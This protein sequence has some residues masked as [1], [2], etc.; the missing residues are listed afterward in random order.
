MTICILLMSA[1]LACGSGCSSTGSS[2]VPES[3]DKEP[4]RVLSKTVPVADP[5]IMVEKGKYYLYGTK[6]GEALGFDVYVSN[7]LEKW[8]MYSSAL[9]PSDSYGTTGFW[10]P[11]V[12]YVSAKKKYYMFY[13]AERRLCVAESSSPL[14]AFVQ[15]FKK[16]MRE[17]AGIDSS[18]F[19]DTDGKAYIYFVRFNGGN[20]IWGAELKDDLK[21][22]KE[23]TL[24]RCIRPDQP[25]ELIASKVTE[26]PSVFKKDGV[27][28]L[29]Y[30][31]NDYT[32]QDYAVGYATSSSPLGPWKK[33]DSN[34]VLHKYE[35]LVGVG[36]GAPFVDND[37][38]MRY[39][40][41][42]HKS[43]TEVHPRGAYI[44][45]MNV[46][47]GKISMGGGLIKPVVVDR[48]AE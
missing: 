39:V 4:V 14:G 16:P 25:W 15:T 6:N 8:K 17:E 9:D 29:M 10:A 34:P 24:S 32:S 20:I 47:D 42:A 22:I 28:Y 11:E 35:G 21:E 23:E 13:T 40:F 19:F 12:Y 33:A 30:S 37:G 44:V 41:H 38:Q 5:Y 27:Y 36:H 43:D 48:L 26:G 2:D 45:D 1:A 7:D 3:P 18:V 31:A 46:K